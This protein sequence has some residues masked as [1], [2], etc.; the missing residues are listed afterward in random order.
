MRYRHLHEYANAHYVGAD[1]RDS[2]S[3]GF[4]CP[5]RNRIVARSA[6]SRLVAVGGR[7]SEDPATTAMR[8]QSPNISV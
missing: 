8:L 7:T 4:Y 3:G 1:M 5:G 2:P 6:V